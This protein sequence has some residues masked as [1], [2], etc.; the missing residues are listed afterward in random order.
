MTAVMRERS[1]LGLEKEYGDG[2]PRGR[3]GRGQHRRRAPRE[4]GLRSTVAARSKGGMVEVDGGGT[5]VSTA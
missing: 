3:K 5:I 2:A 1:C 4:A